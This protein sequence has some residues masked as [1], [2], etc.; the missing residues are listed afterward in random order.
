MKTRI[1]EIIDGKNSGWPPLN[2]E[3]Q[4]F[5][6]FYGKKFHFKCELRGISRSKADF[7]EQKTIV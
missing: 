1:F 6:I 7:G 4:T 5:C 2:R 3:A